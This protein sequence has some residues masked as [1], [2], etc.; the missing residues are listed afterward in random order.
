VRAEKIRIAAPA[1]RLLQFAEIEA[2]RSDNLLADAA[3]TT[4]SSTEGWGWSVR[5]VNDGRREGVGWS[6]LDPPSATRTEWIEFALPE[7]RPMNRV[8]LYPRTDNPGGGFPSDFTVESYRD[9]QWHALLTQTGV[10]SPGATPRRFTF[11]PQPVQRLRIR[12]GAGRLL[13]FA[14]IEA[15]RSD[16]LL[17]DAAVSASSSTEAYGWSLRYAND[18]VSAGIGWSSLDPPSDSRPEWIE[19]AFPGPRTLNQVDLYPR[20]DTSPG[21]GFPADFMIQ[22]LRDGQWHT[23][24]SR[25]GHPYPG[26]TPQRF[27]FAAQPAERVRILAGAGRLLQFAE[28]T[29]QH[30]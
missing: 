5:Y 27:R 7:A 10:P 28:I 21:G 18:G 25:T 2:Y 13:Q 1:G 22:V 26:V 14:E 8:D 3:V 20:S 4:S 30:I 15:H 12:A 29:A 11:A 19:F 17:A 6:S 24:L 9:G 23:V 16:N